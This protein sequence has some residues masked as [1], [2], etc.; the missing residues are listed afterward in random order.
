MLDLKLP[1]AAPDLELPE[2]EEMQNNNNIQGAAFD[3]LKIF[4]GII[5]DDFNRN[6]RGQLM[7]TEHKL[8]D[9]IRRKKLALGIK[10]SPL[11][12]HQF[13]EV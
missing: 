11:E 8:K 4:G 1:D 2:S 5:S 12:T 13:R 7:R 9:A 10:E 6:Y 3:L